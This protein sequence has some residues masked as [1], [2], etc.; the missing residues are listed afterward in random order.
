MYKREAEKGSLA[1]R[2]GVVRSSTFSRRAAVPVAIA[3]PA[4]IIM[5][6]HS[7]LASPKSQVRQSRRGGDA[8]ISLIGYTYI[9]HLEGLDKREQRTSRRFFVSG[10]SSLFEIHMGGFVILGR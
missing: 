5:A 9:P 7:P 10:F 6:P 8:K 2:N 4:P 1:S 3:H